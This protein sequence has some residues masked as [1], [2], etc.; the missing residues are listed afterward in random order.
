MDP[1]AP[2]IVQDLLSGSNDWKNIQ[3]IVKLTFRA[4]ADV[5]RQQGLALRELERLAP[6]KA[7]K[8]ELNAGLSLK[9]NVADVSRTV[10]DLASG[11]EQKLA[12]EDV[13]SLLD[14]RVSKGDLQYLLSNKVSVEELGRVLE[15]KASSHEVSAQLSTLQGRVDELQ[16]DLAKRLSACAL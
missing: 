5:L 9:A 8:A 12:F 7:S 3:D 1:Y 16:R 11:L 4:V 6:T 10:A 15:H 13:Q 14:D 2:S